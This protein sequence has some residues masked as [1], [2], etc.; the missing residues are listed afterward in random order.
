MAQDLYLPK[1]SKETDS[2]AIQAVAETATYKYFYY[3]DEFLNWYILRKTLA[4]G[5]YAYGK[6]SGG[7]LSVYDSPTTDPDPMPTFGT[8]GAIF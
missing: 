7:Y 1:R 4:T 2:Y 6:G 3:E 5:V 8:Y